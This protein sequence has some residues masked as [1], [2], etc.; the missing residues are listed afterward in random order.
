MR[1]FALSD[2]AAGNAKQASALANLLGLSAISLTLQLHGVDRQLAPRFKA[3]NLQRTTIGEPHALVTLAAWI[4]SAQPD[5]VIGCGRA[6][7]AALRAIKQAKASCKTIQ[8]LAPECSARY[9][10][11]VICPQHDRL[12][13]PNVLTSLGAIH[14]IES[15]LSPNCNQCDALLVLLGQASKNA[16]WTTN[17]LRALLAD[18]RTWPGPIYLST[19]RRSGFDI[20]ALIAASPLSGH[21][22]VEIYRAGDAAPN[23]YMRWLLS[24]GKIVVTPDS[25]NMIS[26]AMATRA[27][28]L[29]PWQASAHGK[30]ARFFQTNQARLQGFDANSFSR[31]QTPAA[32]HADCEALAQLLKQKLGFLG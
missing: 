25:V 9:F 31:E 11:W 27:Q 6:A 20:D 10:D 13:G 3:A 24:A 14:T 32:P 26:E 18:L 8:I 7:A 21:A 16:P 1:A 5:L 30:I 17:Q 4:D 23:P 28:L 22:R 2:G 29:V 12:R 19:S 15:Q